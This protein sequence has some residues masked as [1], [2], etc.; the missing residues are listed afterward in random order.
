MN[1]KQKL[2]LK[3]FLL[4]AA[5]SLGLAA[6]ARA[7]DSVVV[8]QQSDVSAAART[9]GDLSLLGQS[10]ATL[11]Y[12]YIDLDGTSTSADRYAFEWNQPLND[13]FDAVLSYDYLQSGLFGGSRVKQHTLAASLRAFSTA[14]SWGK[15][16]LEA[17]AGY[18]WQRFAGARD[19]SWLWSVGAGVEF[20]VLPRA[21]VTPFVKY[22]DVPDLANEGRWNYGVKG[23]YWL[24][25]NWALTAGFSR[26]D[27]QN[28]EFTV[29]TNFRF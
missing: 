3:S 19:D 29:G 2:P 18:V 1:M 22:A 11:T 27:E 10:H 25:R 28:S 8:T 15:P 23:S 24:D 7:D 5:F 14:Y 4:A 9:T 16:Y 21:T 13:G 20:Q 26:D 6:S 17:G 12:G